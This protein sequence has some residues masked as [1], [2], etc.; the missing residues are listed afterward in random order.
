[1]KWYVVQVRPKQEY[2]ALENLEQQYDTVFLPE[3]LIDLRHKRRIKRDREALFPGY[4][5]IRL[6]KED[7]WGPIRS[8]RGVIGLVKFGQ[9]IPYIK[10]ECLSDFMKIKHQTDYQV[11]DK[12]I[13]NH[14]ESFL[15]IPAIVKMNG[16]DRVQVLM[17]LLGS[18]RLVSVDRT[19]KSA[20]GLI[21]KPFH[22]E[23]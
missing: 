4:L 7:D 6:S 10:D 20:G 19:H 18:E 22:E 16:S 12:V 17:T 3:K 2:I 13:F 9:T 5:L 11:G 1:M 8:T 23:K 15:N 21:M 14:K